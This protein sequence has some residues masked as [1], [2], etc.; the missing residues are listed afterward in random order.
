MLST[1]GEA[2]E[3]MGYPRPRDVT[4]PCSGLACGPEDD[5][6]MALYMQER[7]PALFRA[8][9]QVLMEHGV[10]VEHVAEPQI[11]TAAE[12]VLR[13]L[14]M[15][16]LNSQP[17]YLWTCSQDTIARADTPIDQ[18]LGCI[19]ALLHVVYEDAEHVAFNSRSVRLQQAGI[20]H[21][22]RNAPPFSTEVNFVTG[23]PHD[24]IGVLLTDK[25][26]GRTM[27]SFKTTVYWRMFRYRNP[28][29]PPA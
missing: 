29:E 6:T 11:A 16:S 2:V 12:G 13:Q 21:H 9:E 20:Q 27:V 8:I 23:Q 24:C 5:W 26:D 18:L 4:F 25:G 22:P 19:R 15:C 3:G 7:L 17:A 14:L 28:N 1:Y 10:I